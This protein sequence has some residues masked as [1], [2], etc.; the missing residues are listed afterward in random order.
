M[1]STI[2][3]LHLLALALW[4]GSVRVMRRTW[5]NPEDARLN[6]GAEAEV[7]HADVQRVKRAHMNALENAI[8]FFVVGLLY[9]LTGAS[10]MGAMIY[11]YT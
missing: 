1:T 6:K 4:T 3:G 11:F 7:D 5:V 8:P 9:V 10:A 2:L